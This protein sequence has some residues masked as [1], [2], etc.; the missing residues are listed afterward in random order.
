MPAFS[1]LWRFSPP[2]NP[3][4]SHTHLMLLLPSRCSSEPRFYAAMTLK[5]NTR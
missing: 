3:P 4:S 2:Q 1:S 5:L